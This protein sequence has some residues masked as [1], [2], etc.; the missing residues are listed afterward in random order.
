MTN[1]E[2]TEINTGIAMMN[3]KMWN[4]FKKSHKEFNFKTIDGWLMPITNEKL[5]IPAHKTQIITSSYKLEYIRM[6]ET[7]FR[8]IEHFYPVRLNPRV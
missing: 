3:I 4:E 6:A 7:I 1:D 8:L 5:V 2:I